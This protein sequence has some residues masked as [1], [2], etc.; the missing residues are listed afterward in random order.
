MWQYCFPFHFKTK[1][2]RLGWQNPEPHALKLVFHRWRK[3][4]SEGSLNHSHIWDVDKPAKFRELPL[5]VLPLIPKLPYYWI[6]NAK[7]LPVFWED[8]AFVA[9]YT[10]SYLRGWE[11]LTEG[12]Q[13]MNPC[14]ESSFWEIIYFKI[15]LYHYQLYTQRCF[16][17]LQRH[18]LDHIYCCS[19][20]NSQEL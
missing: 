5:I 9:V 1:S 4:D 13:G 18:L 8:S 10:A 12:R 11:L 20:H 2:L 16:I 3:E 15:Q 7:V 17:L 6:E 14:F 19:F